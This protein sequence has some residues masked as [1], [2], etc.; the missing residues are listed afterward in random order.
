MWDTA[1]FRRGIGYT[2]VVGKGTVIK[3]HIRLRY[4]KGP[5]GKTVVDLVNEALARWAKCTPSEFSRRPRS[6]DVIDK[7]KMRETNM[8][9]VNF[10]PAV[11]LLPDVKQ[12][13][14]ASSFEAFLK[15]VAVSRLIGGFTLSPAKDEH[16][17][18][19]ERLIT[20]YI[21]FIKRNGRV[22]TCPYTTHSAIHLP[23]EYRHY[24][25]RLGNISAYPFENFIK[26]FK[27]VSR[28]LL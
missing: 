17:K 6:L 19:A 24:G 4:T 28:L 9:G 23:D 1:T 13:L 11:N 8:T 15:L 10:L 20:E 25:T 16:A 7:W 2:F 18:V 5:D 26:F 3:D 21:E 27:P 22:D 12:R 14:D